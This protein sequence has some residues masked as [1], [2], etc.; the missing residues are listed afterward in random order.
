[1][2]LVQV[3]LSILSSLV[4]VEVVVVMETMVLVVVAQ[5]DSLK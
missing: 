1:V 4:V 3:K 5:A 2:L